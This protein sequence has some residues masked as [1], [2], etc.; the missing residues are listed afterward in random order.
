MSD[1]GD[2]V[3]L[4]AAIAATGSDLAI[5]GE[6]NL[7]ITLFD[8]T[9]LVTPS[10][11]RLAELQV[12]DLVAIDASV[13][14]A[15]VDTCQTDADWLSILLASRVDPAAHRPTVEVAL[16]AVISGL[17]GECVIVHTHPTD[18][19]AIVCS[20]R[21][22]RF[23]TTRLFPDHVVAL[24]VADAVIPYIDPGRRLAVATRDAIV[25]H[26]SEYGE[27]PRMILAENHGVFAIG[28]T[29]REAFDRT[30]MVTKAAQ[31][32]LAGGDRGLTRE[33]IE[34]IAGREDEAYRR[35]VL[36]GR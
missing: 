3:Q 28:A 13:L 5:A 35:A 9:L 24:G 12:E 1:P 30:L 33:E 15:A 25:R 29:A 2:L 14:L 17:M 18:V 22:T 27:W 7:S 34:R 32:F 8:G 23:A 19:L 26:R 10:G 11:S 20:T 6:G 31:I 16:H 4:A 21:A 36:A